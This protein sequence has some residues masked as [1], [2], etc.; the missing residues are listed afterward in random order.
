MAE[1]V[2]HDLVLTR[3]REFRSPDGTKKN[4]R[5]AKYFTKYSEAIAFADS[6]RDTDR[7]LDSKVPTTFTP[8]H[9][10]QVEALVPYFA[11]RLAGL[12]TKEVLHE[13]NI[14]A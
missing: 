13:P 4:Y 8:E 9:S 1:Y 7:Y 2:D 11:L 12:S 3:I 10:R 5:A 14:E 6:I